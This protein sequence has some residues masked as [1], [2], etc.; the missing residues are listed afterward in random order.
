MHAAAEDPP[1]HVGEGIFDAAAHEPPLRGAQDHADE[2]LVIL[3]EGEALESGQIDL[4]RMGEVRH[5][6]ALR[7]DR[8]RRSMNFFA[9]FSLAAHF[10]AAGQ[11]PITP[12]ERAPAHRNHI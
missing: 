3:A 5:H 7:R 6:L 4:A 2:Q 11:L 10:R 12:A 8:E 9:Q 1:E